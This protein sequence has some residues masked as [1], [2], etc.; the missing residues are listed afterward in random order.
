[1]KKY[2]FLSPTLFLGTIVLSIGVFIVP[3]TAQAGFQWVAPVDNAAPAPTLVPT[4]PSISAEPPVIITAAPAPTLMETPAPVISLPE[5]ATTSVTI[6]PPPPVAVPVSQNAAPTADDNKP[7]RGFANNVPLVVAMRQILPPDYGFSVAQ[8]VSMGKLVSWRG[9]GS[10]RQTLQ[11]MLQPVG[12]NMKED[13]Q[14]ISVIHGR[15][16]VADTVPT[17]VPAPVLQPAPVLEAPPGAMA[18]DAPLL[19]VPSSAVPAPMSVPMAS[20]P[21]HVLMPPPGMVDA[22]ASMP[23]NAELGMEV[24]SA[25]TGDT[26]RKILE[27]WCQ[28][29]HIDLSWQAEYDYPLQAAVSFTGTFEEAVRNLLLGFQDAQPQ[30]AASLHNNQSAGQAVLVVETRGN[31]YSD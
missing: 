12:L 26:L 3:V 29:A 23:M 7:V 24:W 28:R 15:E 16:A 11:E 5:M 10:W 27:Q 4:V 30:P 21:E 9:G 31:N 8:D 17:S 22:M 25:N 13:G 6:V 19:L 18:V 1:M 2:S 20:G 14:M